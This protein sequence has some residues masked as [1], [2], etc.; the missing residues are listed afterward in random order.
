M[1]SQPLETLIG[2]VEEISVTTK[3]DNEAAHVS[4]HSMVAAA[5]S[6]YEK[7]RYLLDYRE[8]H[9]IR[10]AAV[11]RIVHRLFFIEGKS[12]DAGALR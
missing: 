2:R 6:F 4:V 3:H 9:M 7:V 12:I 11:E 10:R 8:E 1:L 5:A